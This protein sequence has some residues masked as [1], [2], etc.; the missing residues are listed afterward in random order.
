[1]SQKFFTKFCHKNTISIHTIETPTNPS[2]TKLGQITTKEDAEEYRFLEALLVHQVDGKL[3]KNATL[4]FGTL[5]SLLQ[6]DWVWMNRRTFSPLLTQ[7]SNK[8][9]F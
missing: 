6:N 4:L 3:E 2:N 5:D 1:M 9:V 7:F 8:T